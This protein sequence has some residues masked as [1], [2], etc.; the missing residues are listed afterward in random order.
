MDSASPI[1]DFYPQTFAL[2]PNGKRFKWQAVA[3]L[4]FIEQARLLEVM[5]FPQEFVYLCTCVLACLC[6]CMRVSRVLPLKY[7]YIYT[8]T[9]THTHTNTHTHT[10]THKHTH[11]HTHTHMHSDILTYT[12]T[13]AHSDIHTSSFLAEPGFS[14]AHPG[15]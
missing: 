7:A 8:R 1:A 14:C 13:R 4:P 11:T 10:H 3:L 9:R 15:R 12:H 6:V 5:D 2:D